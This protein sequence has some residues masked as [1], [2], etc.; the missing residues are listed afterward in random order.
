MLTSNRTKVV[1]EISRILHDAF[2]WALTKDR[3]LFEGIF[4]QDDDF[5]TYYPDSKS[6]VIGWG[7]F[8][9]FLDG[10]MDP[11]NI[12]KGFDIRDLRIVI[13]KSGD[14]A[15]FSAVVDDEGEFDGKPWGTR[16]IRWT[17]VLEKRGG[18]WRICQQHMSEANDNSQ[19]EEN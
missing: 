14:V 16:D 15:W 6:T 18:N 1:N 8:E 4:A 13:S 10:W 17:G 5:F 19:N 7:Q 2:G 3:A 12:A 9:K 11:R